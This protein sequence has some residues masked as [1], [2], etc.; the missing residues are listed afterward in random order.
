MGGSGER[1]VIVIKP[2]VTARCREP[3]LR[4]QVVIEEALRGHAPSI[5]K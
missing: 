3:W 1:K 4:T 5:T 2:L